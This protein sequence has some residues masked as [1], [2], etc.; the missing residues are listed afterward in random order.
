MNR[1]SARFG[2]VTAVALL[3]APWLPANATV[4]SLTVG[5]AN[6]Q[7]GAETAP[8]CYAT[9][10]LS[11]QIVGVTDSF[12]GGFPAAQSEL[13]NFADAFNNWNA[14]HGGAWHLVDG[15]TLPISFTANVTVGA[16]TFAGG[17]NPIIISINYNPTGNDP[18]L[19]QLVWTQA[20][21][22]NYTPTSTSV[23][24]PPDVTLDTYSFSAGSGG[25]GGA[26]Q[27]AC[28]QIPGQTPGP[29]NTIAANIGATASGQAFCDPIYP[30]QYGPSTSAGPDPFADAPQGLWPSDAFRGIALL[31]TV[32]FDTDANGNVIDRVLTAYEGISYG[33]NLSVPEPA[34]LLLLSGPTLGA[35]MLRRRR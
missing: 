21:V 9:G 8:H 2:P 12:I 25:S 31:S 23:L 32:T 15:G 35:L 26:F 1:L 4:Q 17:I 33:F 27:T 13:F 22:T 29:S 3:L 18:S 28:E 19:A 14:S 5:V 30:F 16:G 24:S 10:Y 34:T 6:C 20:L 11:S 7:F